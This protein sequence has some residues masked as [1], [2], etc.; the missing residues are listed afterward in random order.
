MLLYSNNC[1]FSGITKII[2]ILHIVDHTKL[3]VIQVC[4]T[5]NY[6]Y[7]HKHFEHIEPQ[8]SRYKLSYTI[9]GSNYS[10][11]YVHRNKISFRRENYAS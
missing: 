9:F 1:Y 5:S 3:N 2:V 6:E 4:I 8:S 7:F 10:E 11:D